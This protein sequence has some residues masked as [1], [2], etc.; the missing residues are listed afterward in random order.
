MPQADVNGTTIAYRIDGT[1]D[2]PW[3]MLSNSLG[4]NLG[5][6]DHQA[7]ALGRR[8][9]IIRYDSRGHGASGVPD[10]PYTIEMLG[11]DALGLL[12]HLGV[13]RTHFVGLS[14]GGMVGQWLGANAPGRLDRL[15]LSN[16][17]SHMAP[18]E[19]W[20]ARIE[21]VLGRGMAAVADSVLDRWFTPS[22]RERS[23]AEV[24][25]VR[26]ML[27]ATRPEGYAAC[28][29]AIRDMDFRE[30]N[31][32]ITVPT[33]VI[34]GGMDPAT[35]VAHA[36][37][38]AAAIR[39]SELTVIDEAAHLANIEQADAYNRILADFLSR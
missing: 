34:A 36:E 14:K 30:A 35:P 27:V 2:G 3:L 18:P 38:I 17:S 19:L 1:A 22:F 21:A 37:L 32:A 12:D 33:L 23:A 7:A 24:A 29:A 5:M 10:G 15:V 4:T 28:C 9:R 25:R 11:R 31:R 16:T 26:E 13:E 8:F 6:W 39:G 20:D